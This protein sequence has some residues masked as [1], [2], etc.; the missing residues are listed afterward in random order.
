MLL[1]FVRFAIEKG[2]RNIH[3][4]R[5][6]TEIKT[7]IGAEPKALHAYLKMNNGLVNSTLPYFLK[8]S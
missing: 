6:A 5:T 1:D 3:F 7:T 8:S 4:G 2:K